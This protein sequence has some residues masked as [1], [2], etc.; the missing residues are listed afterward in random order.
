MNSVRA[1]VEVV[2]C[3]PDVAAVDVGDKP[4]FNVAVA[5]VEE[6]F[7]GHGRAQIGAADTDVDD[8]G[9]RLAGVAPPLLVA[10]LVGKGR[11]PVQDFVHVRH[12]VVAIRHDHLRSRG[13]QGHMKD[14]AVLG[15][16]DVFTGPH[17]LHALPD[18]GPLSHRDE[19]GDGFRGQA[20]LG[21]VEV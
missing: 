18:A 19:Q 14:G 6:G 13:A 12:H 1:G 8:G 20:V 9:D 17:G 10:D 5:V 7:I 16:V 21:V 11:H 15:D 3:F 2:G 4:A